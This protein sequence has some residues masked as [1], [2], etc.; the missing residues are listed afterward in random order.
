MRKFSNFSLLSI[1]AAT[2]NAWVAR[3]GRR[4]SPGGNIVSMA[5]LVRKIAALIAIYAIA[6]QSLLL[7]HVRAAHVDVD[8]LAVICKSNSSGGPQGPLPPRAGDWH[9]CCLACDGASPVAVPEGAT[10]SFALP[11]DLAPPQWGV[12]AVPSPTKHQPH[13]S[14]APPFAA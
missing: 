11:G 13:A 12:E 7:S 10:F 1:V 2:S 3:P 5:R 6:L 14:R 8:P 9:S 4:Q